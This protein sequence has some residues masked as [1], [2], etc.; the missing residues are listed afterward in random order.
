MMNH[1]IILIILVL[2]VFAG[3][4]TTTR[5]NY[6]GTTLQFFQKLW[7]ECELNDARQSSVSYSVL[8][9]DTFI[10]LLNTEFFWALQTAQ[11]HLS[12]ILVQV[13]YTMLFTISKKIKI[14]N[15]PLPTHILFL[16]NLY[17][18]FTCT[19]FLMTF[20]MILSLCS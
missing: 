11:V 20:C 9:F 4:F 18:P 7:K 5:S 19:Y 10:C 15:K 12:S 13:I 14:K 16:T 3:I 8:Y 2:A 1:Y 17:S 6:G